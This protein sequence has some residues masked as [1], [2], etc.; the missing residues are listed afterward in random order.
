[1]RNKRQTI[2]KTLRAAGRTGR[3]WTA[4]EASITLEAAIALPLFL[5]FVVTVMSV[6]DMI[7]LESNMLAALHQTGSRMAWYGFYYRYG[8]SDLLDL[9]AGDSTYDGEIG[10]DLSELGGMAV[11]VVLSELYVRGQVE[12]QLGCGYLDHT[13][14]EGGSGGIS[15]LRSSI[16]AGDDCIDLVADYRAKPFFPFPG[17]ASISLESRF[18]GHAWVGYDV[19]AGL[20]DHDKEDGETA[21]V[22]PNGTVYHRTRE[23][24]YLKP[25]LQTVSAAGLI[26]ARNDSGGRYYPCEFCTPPPAASYII[27]PEGNRY[28]CSAECRG[29]RRTVI[30]LP[31]EEARKR[32]P[33]CSKCGGE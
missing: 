19:G 32:Y 14:L 22:T 10:A 23:C 28:H 12:D 2:T 31:L 1:M 20:P 30:E 16:L 25:R 17:L 18:Y 21:Y 15:Y 27:T 33:P 24:T 5:F 26:S 4:A 13:C 9:E 6:L 11:S 8:L 7:R 3:T 29:L